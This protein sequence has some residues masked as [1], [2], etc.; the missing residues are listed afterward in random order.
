MNAWLSSSQGDY[1]K[2]ARLGA[3]HGVRYCKR[4]LNEYNIL[5]KINDSQWLEEEFKRITKE[6]F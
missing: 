6:I 2:W 1:C 5:L 4:N 3:I